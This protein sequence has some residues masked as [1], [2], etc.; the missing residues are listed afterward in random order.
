MRQAD[1]APTRQIP[2]A[3]ITA[4]KARE[5]EPA[6]IE[7]ASMISIIVK[8]MTTPSTPAKMIIRQSR[9]SSK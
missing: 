2:K 1:A 4:A 5:I 8:A 9:Y 3:P 7:W 6:D